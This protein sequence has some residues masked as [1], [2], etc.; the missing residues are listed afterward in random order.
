MSKEQLG[1]QTY[2]IFSVFGRRAI[3]TVMDIS[4]HMVIN[5]SHPARLALIIA[6]ELN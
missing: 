1:Q 5:I 6:L 3:T 4:P 2:I